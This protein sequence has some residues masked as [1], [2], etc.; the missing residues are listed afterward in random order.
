MVEWLTVRAI[1]PSARRALALRRSSG[2]TN[3]CTMPGFSAPASRTLNGSEATRSNRGGGH[4]IRA[5][6]LAVTRHLVGLTDSMSS[7][8]S[9]R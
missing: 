3:R 5:S 8:R 2:Q 6:R 4:L 1:L 7:S 9:I